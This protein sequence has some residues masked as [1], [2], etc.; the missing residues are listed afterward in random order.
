[1]ARNQAY[2]IVE[3]ATI[4]QSASASSA[5][6]YGAYRSGIFIIPGTFTGTHIS[7]KVGPDGSTWTDL[8][9]A[10]NAII[11]ITVAAS[12]A[13]PFPAEAL[14]AK[15]VQLLSDGTEAGARS[16]TCLLKS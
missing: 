3:I 12:R 4:A 15:Y 16:I 7:F 8:Y 2:A 13:Y 10:A 1:M 9:T 14:G 5:I 11:S 6:L